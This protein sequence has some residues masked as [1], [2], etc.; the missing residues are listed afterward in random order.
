MKLGRR[1]ELLVGAGAFALLGLALCWR[2]LQ[3]WQ[4]APGIALLGLLDVD[5]L[6]APWNYIAASWN[7]AL[8]IGTLIAVLLFVRAR[9]TPPIPGASVRPAPDTADA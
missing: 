3:L 2:A 6:G 1:A 7:G 8:G 9:W 4:G 5:D